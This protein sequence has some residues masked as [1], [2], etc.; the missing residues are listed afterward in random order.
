ME[1]EWRGIYSELLSTINDPLRPLPILPQH[2]TQLQDLLV[3]KVD[4]HLLSSTD[5]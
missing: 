3:E 4:V 5:R 1:T 2:L